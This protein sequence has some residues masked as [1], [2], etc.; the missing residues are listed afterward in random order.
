MQLPWFRSVVY[1]CKY[2]V[3]CVDVLGRV[4]GSLVVGS[5]GVL[6]FSLFIFWWVSSCAY[7]FIGT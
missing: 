7:G 3:S 5:R 1:W 2:L 4:A 6:M